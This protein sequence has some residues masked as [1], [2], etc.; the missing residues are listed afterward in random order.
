MIRS[1]SQRNIRQVLTHPEIGSEIVVQGW[2][3]TKRES[4]AGFAF[5]EV[6]DGS[7]F[8]NLQVVIPATLPNYSTDIPKLFA[9]AS[10]SVRGEI[11]LS[12]GGKQ[13][14]EM[15]AKEAFLLGPCDPLVYHQAGIK[16]LQPDGFNNSL[17]QV[18]SMG[19][20]LD[21][22]GLRKNDSLAL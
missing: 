19:D 14:V 13:N 9:G 1:V 10:V 18:V 4:K 20:D 12:Q 2:V 22:M 11:V 6:N 15:Q 8:Q 7:Y 21:H 5:L 3:R 17:Y 16:H